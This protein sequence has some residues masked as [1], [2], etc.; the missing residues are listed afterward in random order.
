[1]ENICTVFV[2][3][4]F[5][6]VLR[7][8]NRNKQLLTTYVFVCRTSSH[9]DLVEPLKISKEFLQSSSS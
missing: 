2:K 9:K 8:M 7:S 1:M 3:N 4:T 6:S 5:I